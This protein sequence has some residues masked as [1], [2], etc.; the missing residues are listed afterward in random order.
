MD[1]EDDNVGAGCGG[2]DGGNVLVVVGKRWLMPVL[3]ERA[4]KAR[5]GKVRYLGASNLSGWQLQR[6]VDLSDKMG[7]SPFIS[8][9]MG[10][11]GS[12]SRR[13]R[14]MSR[15]WRRRSSS[16]A[17]LFVIMVVLSF[18][19]SSPSSSLS[20][21]LLFLKPYQGKSV[22]VKKIMATQYG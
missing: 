19:S 17:T 13:R 5:E 14:R 2:V 4:N 6:M 15:R 11:S 1:D 9:Q 21:L 12:S 8:V 7:L 22:F 18:L 3:P 20:L 10:R 16:S